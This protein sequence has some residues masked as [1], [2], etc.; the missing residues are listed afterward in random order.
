MDYIPNIVLKEQM[1]KEIGVKD[2][3]ELFSD[4]PEKIRLKKLNLPDGKTEMQV[5]KEVTDILRKNKKTLSFL[6][7]GV[8][9]QYVPSEIGRAHV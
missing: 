8:Y 9:S 5:K 6:G 3:D 4:I 2:I 1:L 7:C